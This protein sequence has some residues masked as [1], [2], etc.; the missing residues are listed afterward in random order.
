MR[1]SPTTWALID[2]SPAPWNTYSN[3][4][5]NPR[6]SECFLTTMNFLVWLPW[7]VAEKAGDVRTWIRSFSWRVLID[8]IVLIPG[9]IKLSHIVTGT[10]TILLASS[11][12]FFFFSLAYTS[13]ALYWWGYFFSIIFWRTILVVRFSSWPMRG[14]RQMIHSFLTLRESKRHCLQ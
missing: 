12:S 13:L 5:T 2:P 14:L 9:Y 3:L 8:I 11:S 6:M 1:D 7:L 10:H 4:S